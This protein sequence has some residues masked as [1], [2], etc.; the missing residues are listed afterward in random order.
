[1][2]AK[3]LIVEDEPGLL[4]GLHH[5][6]QFEG[7]EVVTAANGKDGIRAALKD[8]PD[9]IVLD[10][11]LPE[12]SGFDVLKDFRERNAAT[13][14]LILTAR[15][16]EADIVKGFDLG[17]D[18]YV[19]KPFSVAELLA[20]VRALLKRAPAADEAGQQVPGTITFGDVTM[21]LQNREVKKNGELVQFSFKEFEL[22]KY[23]ALRRGRTVSRDELLQEIWGV[24]VEAGVTTRTVDTHIANI[25]GKLTGGDVDRPFIVTVHKVGY[26]FVG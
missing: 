21:D 12:K 19:T 15:N 16:F 26:K 17:A 1:M 18:D 8:K 2:A 14:V 9:L 3:I 20:R 7:Y 11:M 13:P 22:L 23:L 24:D 4:E 6:F 10:L 5:N 25:R